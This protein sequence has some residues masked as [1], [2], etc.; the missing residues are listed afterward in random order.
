MKTVRHMKKYFK[1]LVILSVLYG[2]NTDS[3]AQCSK[4]CKDCKNDRPTATSKTNSTMKTGNE[5]TLSCKLTS[6]ELRKRKEQVIAKLKKQ[7]IEKQALTNGFKYKFKGTDELLDEITSFIKS[8]RQCCDFFN[9]NIAV[10]ND[11]FI[12]LEISGQDG[13]K[14]FITS[15]L[16][17]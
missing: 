8:E 1:L 10:N 13:A 16:E 3:E 2:C 14:E 4:N 15:E 12:W 17:M 5:K 9:F 6:P 11:S 7:V